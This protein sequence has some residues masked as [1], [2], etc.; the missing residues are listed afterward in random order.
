[1]GINNRSLPENMA[2]T[3]VMQ[4]LGVP[5]NILGYRYL[6]EA[7]LITVDNP[8]AIYNMTK[9][10]YP[11][12][13]KNFN[14]T[15]SRVERGIRHAI[16]HIWDNNGIETMKS[17]RDSPIYGVKR[18]PTNSQLIAA[19]CEFLLLHLQANTNNYH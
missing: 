10:L 17:N 9:V 14:T 11:M 8:D 12:V 4:E 18:K 2:V 19:I 3:R 5:A 7:I 15:P 13:A 1:M 6:R 16:T